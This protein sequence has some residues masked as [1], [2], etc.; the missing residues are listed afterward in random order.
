[1]S[2]LVALGEGYR[3]LALGLAYPEPESLGR[4]LADARALLPELVEPLLA[5]VDDELVG[6]HVRLLV[7][8]VPV[9]PHEG[10]F[11]VCDRGSLLGQLAALYELFGARV[12]GREREASDHIAVQLEF[13]ALLCI[14]QA[15][16]ADRGDAEQLEIARRA[17]RVLLE[18]HLGPFGVAFGERLAVAAMHPFYEVLGELIVDFISADA[19]ALGVELDPLAPS[20]SLPVV[21]P[22]AMVCP[23]SGAEPKS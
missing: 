14:K 2:S 15:L 3:L 23:L 16:A 9:S 21:E 11:R 7:T 18:E 22:D 10:S 6:E 17:R 4:A 12:G 5:H 20:R 19:D 8:S 1:M 13:C